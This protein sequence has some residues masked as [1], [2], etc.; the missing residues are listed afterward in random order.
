MN[1]RQIILASSS[2]QRKTILSVLDINFQ[3]VPADLD[4]R[5]VEG[6]NLK[7]RAN[8]L[9]LLKAQTVAK[10]YADA[11][12]IAADTYGDLDGKAL[13]KPRSIQEAKKMLNQ[14]SDRWLSGYTGFAYLDLTNNIKINKVSHFDFKFRKLSKSEI[15]F[16]VENNP[17]TSWSAGF[18]PAYPAGASLIEE[19]RGS[20]TA[21]AYGLPIEWAVEGLRKSGISI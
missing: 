1:K 11:I 10:D 16:Y 15:N 12:V 13:E 20:L 17:V 8:K 6:K 5:E 2:P 14:Q 21:F 19:C 4:E 7:D 9:A 3:I 18:A